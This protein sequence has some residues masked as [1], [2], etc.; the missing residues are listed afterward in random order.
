MDLTHEELKKFRPMDVEEELPRY[1]ALNS[2]AG[3]DPLVVRI[4]TGFV[5]G[6]TLNT[7]TEK[8]VEAWFGIPYAEKPLG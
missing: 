8:E 2:Q 7:A 5:R 3:N 6:M 4:K 1:E